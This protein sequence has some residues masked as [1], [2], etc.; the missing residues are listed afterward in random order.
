M[1]AYRDQGNAGI[2]FGRKGSAIPDGLALQMTLYLGDTSA[3]RHHGPQLRLIDTGRKNIAAKAIENPSEANKIRPRSGMG[4]CARGIGNVE[5]LRIMSPLSELADNSV[6]G[7]DLA[8]GEIGFSQVIGNC[9]MCHQALDIDMIESGESV[10]HAFDL[11]GAETYSPHTRIDL[12]MDRRGHSP[13]RCRFVERHRLINPKD[14]RSK[15]QVKKSIFLSRPRSA[16]DEYRSV[17]TG[18]PKLGT[19][20]EGSNGQPFDTFLLEACGTCR[21]PVSVRVGLDY[22][23]ACDIRADKLSRRPQI[24]REAVQIDL[25]PGWTLEGTG[26]H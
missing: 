18:I 17:Y 4:D 12:D 26:S 23:H 10:E 20:F 13:R 3:D 19:F 16:E 14:G 15:F 8:P 2:S 22:R 7:C 11:V 5:I 25:C 21:C 24:E 6:K 1:I 9:K